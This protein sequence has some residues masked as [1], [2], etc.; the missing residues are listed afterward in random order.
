MLSFRT[1][2]RP[3]AGG[4]GITA[5]AV[6][7]VMAGCGGGAAALPPS[8]DRAIQLSRAG[9][10]AGAAH[11]YEALAKQNSGAHRNDYVFAA[12]SSYLAA[13]LFDDAT[14]VTTLLEQP[15][16]VQQGLQR[17]LLEVEALQTRGQYEEAWRRLN[18]I[19]VPRDPQLAPLAQSYWRLKQ[20]IALASG[21][22]VDA[23]MAQDQLEPN[24]ATLTEIRSS[25]GQLL[26]ALRDAAENGMKPGT[27]KDAVVRGWL[28]LAPLALKAKRDHDAAV[29]E[30][31]AWLATHPNHPA[32][33]A[34]RSQ[35][36]AQQAPPPPSPL[37]VISVPASVEPQPAA[38]MGAPAP[39][40]VSA[41][42]LP[43]PV[44]AAPPPAAPPVT[45]APAQA[46]VPA[47]GALPGAPPPPSPPL[48]PPAQG[49]TV[50]ALLLP[51][52]GRAASLADT[53]RDGFMTAYYQAPAA[54]RPRVRLYDTSGTGGISETVGR[55]VQEGATFIVGPLTREEVTAAAELTS[56]HPPILAL[57]FL[58]T[59]APVPGDFY[60]YAL[61]PE[62]EARLAA[63]RILGEGRHQGVALV[64]DG[65]WG[66]RVLDAFQQE[67][68]T[69][70]G[71]L[72]QWDKVYS[73]D[74]DF[75]EAITR[76]LRINESLARHKRLE[77]VLGTKLQ[78]EP[79]RRTDIDF[80]FTPAPASLERQLRPQLRFHYA[81]SIPTYAT[82]DAF[83]PNPRANEDLEGL[84]FPDMPWMLA[85][86]EADAVRQ[87]AQS[88]W[89]NNGSYRGRLFAFGYD[90]YKLALDL[91]AA[92]GSV[93][94]DGLTGHL[95]L[96]SEHRVHREL[97][98]LQMHNGEAKLLPATAPTAQANPR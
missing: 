50:I 47:A 34:V 74:T 39:A 53:V 31:Q 71:I 44:A 45:P 80:L 68:E 28:Q 46:A 54:S 96:D 5:A 67:I 75:T 38:P 82:S 22:L 18:T 26:A 32:S 92:T 95:T 20:R 58:A 62:N 70:G 11:V 84:M 83:E 16:S 56:A 36:L 3:G 12:E 61:S 25:R 51:L 55:A 66:K 97:T 90:A 21:R 13:H 6:A 69:G 42:P 27:S 9:D 98:W 86:G 63:Q 88:A 43:A 23:V 79:R 2:C 73:T 85:G 91:R 76:V 87:A 10:E 19:N 60:Q 14:R 89:P 59:G 24:L 57:N 78:F 65:D 35:L 64:P 72:L 48:S 15:L 30:V 94:I 8:V 40:R 93:S 41:A 17:D 49:E 77:T 37:Q 81:G 52:E 29:P 4:W 33:E 1:C 7:L